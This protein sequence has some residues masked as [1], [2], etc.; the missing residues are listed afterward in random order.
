MKKISLSHNVTLFLFAFT[1]TF[2]S[3]K[4][5]E[6]S[7]PTEPTLGPV[8]R[9]HMDDLS[10]QSMK[11]GNGKQ[12]EYKVLLDKAEIVTILFLLKKGE[13]IPAHF[14]KVN[15]AIYIYDGKAEVFA[16]NKMNP[17]VKGDSLYIPQNSVTSVKN[18]NDEITK[19]FFFFP[20]GF[21]KTLAFNIPE[22]TSQDSTGE[23]NQLLKEENVPWENW[24]GKIPVGGKV[25]P[26]A[27][28]TIIDNDSMV[29]GITKI[30]PN[31]DVD[32][33]FHKPTQIVIFSD[34]EGKTHIQKGEYK[35]IKKDHYIYP[36][37]YS[38]HHSINTSKTEPLMEVYFFPTGPFSTIKYLG[39]GKKFW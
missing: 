30:D 25:T 16:Q 3:C 15:K 13:E 32:S 27:W 4:K 39:K 18:T 14:H 28:K 26:L 6:T 24:D 2:S 36:P 5:Q 12:V 35:E 10:I 20:I 29:M 38:V 33:H 34:G 8:E 7:D 37:T 31:N 21:F 11:F 1:L 22:G 9:A 23:K 19:V 17:V